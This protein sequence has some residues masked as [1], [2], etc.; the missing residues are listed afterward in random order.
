MFLAN[1]NKEMLRID[2]C[3]PNGGKWHKTCEKIKGERATYK[4]QS[5]RADVLWT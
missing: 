4:L 1:V 3:Q 2:Q 5:S